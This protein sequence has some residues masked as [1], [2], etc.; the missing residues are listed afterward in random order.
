MK[1]ENLK[2]LS[3]EK[4]DECRELIAV[5]RKEP[6]NIDALTALDAINR[7]YDTFQTVFEENGLYGVKDYD[8]N[9]VVPAA[10][11][12]IA[13][14]YSTWLFDLPIPVIKDNK[15]GLVVPDGTGKI[16]TDFVYDSI[17]YAGTGFMCVCGCKKG[18]ISTVNG[19][20]IIPCIMDEIFDE[21]CGITVV[22]KD[23]KRGYYFNGSLT[24]FFDDDRMEDDGTV[25]VCRR[26]GGAETWGYI[27][28]DGR[29]TRDEDEACLRYYPY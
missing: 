24:E 22:E 18:V 15:V 10:F 5:L 7:G 2:P 14:T 11:D 26:K 23:G 17:R 12:G 19:S 8:G 20:V 13:E 6:G 3:P 9:V 16:M 21:L 27:D 25:M 28:A 29:F 4:R 1:R